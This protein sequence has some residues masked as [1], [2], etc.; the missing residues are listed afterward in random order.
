[1]ILLLV[2]DYITQF[3]PYELKSKEFGTSFPVAEVSI[4]KSNKFPWKG[5]NADS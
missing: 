1:M 3:Q 2:I 4:W 5:K